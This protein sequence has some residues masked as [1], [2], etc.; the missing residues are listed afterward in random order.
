[1][2]YMYELSWVSYL[3]SYKL[4][5]YEVV[6]H[7]Y[8]GNLKMT[9]ILGEYGISAVRPD[10]PT[11]KPSIKE[12]FDVVYTNL[13]AEIEDLRQKQEYLLYKKSKLMKASCS[14]E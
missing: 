3:D 9:R 1:M 12:A 2:K 10:H 4:V 7:E 6:G 5:T 8:F 13:N 11:V 14:D